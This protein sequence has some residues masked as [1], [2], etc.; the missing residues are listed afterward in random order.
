M[1][2]AWGFFFSGFHPPT[3][4]WKTYMLYL[5]ARPSY[6]KK[7]GECVFCLFFKIDIRSFDPLPLYDSWGA[8]K[9]HNGTTYIPFKYLESHQVSQN[10]TQGD[11]RYKFFLKIY[12][13]LCISWCRRGGGTLTNRKNS[14][15]LLVSIPIWKFW[16][17][18]ENQAFRPGAVFLSYPPRAFQN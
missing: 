17:P 10:S 15:L 3:K 1:L 4:F 7:I 18:A 9:A 11:G 6:K 12:S 5:G 14:S 13:W 2:L 16:F 8:Q